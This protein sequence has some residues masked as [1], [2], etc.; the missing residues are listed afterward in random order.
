MTSGEL[1]TKS[2]MAS[3]DPEEYRRGVVRAPLGGDGKSRFVGGPHLEVQGHV[4]VRVG[5]L[6]AANEADG[7]F[8]QGLRLFQVVVFRMRYWNRVSEKVPLRV[9]IARKVVT[10][11]SL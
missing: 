8:A 7:P 3:Q 10:G 6:R 2:A 4:V 5:A 9:P 1:S 11:S